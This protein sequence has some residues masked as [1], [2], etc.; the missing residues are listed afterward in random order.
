MTASREWMSGN[1]AFRHIELSTENRCRSMRERLPS[2]RSLHWSVLGACGIVFGRT[3]GG[4]VGPAELV[5]PIQVFFDFGQ[6]HSQSQSGLD[7][8]GALVQRIGVLKQQF[9][10]F[11]RHAA[12][13]ADRFPTGLTS[14]Q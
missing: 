14:R 8:F 1:I 13:F 12:T 11:V 7:G 10:N 4:C 9:S 5:E 3:I 2:G 6:R